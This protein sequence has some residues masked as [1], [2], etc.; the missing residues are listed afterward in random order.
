MTN[1]EAINNLIKN[2]NHFINSP[3][4]DLIQNIKAQEKGVLQ[5][6][7]LRP[8]FEDFQ[9][10]LRKINADYLVY[11]PEFKFAELERR[12][13]PLFQKVS[14]IQGTTKNPNQ[15]DEY[16]IRS[17]INEFIKGLDIGNP[18]NSGFFIREKGPVW[19]IIIQSITLANEATKTDVDT[20][21]IKKNLLKIE[22]EA[23]EIRQR[24]TSALNSAQT[25]LSKSG[26]EHHADI[27]K[28]QAEQHKENA[29]K[30]NNRAIRLLI[31]TLSLALV[32]F[33]IIAFFI[34]PSETKTLIETSVLAALMI[35]FS[36][37]AFTLAIKN[38]FAEK[39]NESIN[40]H[41]ANCLST[42]NTFIDSAD[43]ERKSA[44]LLQAT[45]TIFSHQSSGFLSKE[46]DVQNPNPIVEIVRNISGK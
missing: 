18:N 12:L 37:Y 1:N 20:R 27:F 7:E 39:H 26:V 42:F 43:I 10:I 41:K 32:F 5:F 22:K 14:Q 25:E 29:K 15:A 44:I 16:Q 35:S 38:Y 3:V 40:Q 2:V 17:I 28:N 8:G 30:W 31:A 23:E 34:D 21:N 46:N 9:E 24:L 11:L 33:I 13:K 36:T 4:S 6:N 45:N 19:D